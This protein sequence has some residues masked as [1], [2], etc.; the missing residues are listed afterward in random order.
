MYIIIKGKTQINNLFINFFF[1]SNYE[2][3]STQY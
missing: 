1:F 3:I 2:Y